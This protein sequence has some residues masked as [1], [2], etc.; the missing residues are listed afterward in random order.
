LVHVPFI[1]AIGCV[2][3][4]GNGLGWPFFSRLHDDAGKEDIFSS[5][6]LCIREKT[7]MDVMS[8]GERKDH[9]HSSHHKS[10]P[11]HNTNFPSKYLSLSLSAFYSILFAGRY[12]S[13]PTFMCGML[14]NVAII[15]VLFP[16]LFILTLTLLGSDGEWGVSIRLHRLRLNRLRLNWLGLHRLYGSRLELW[17]RLN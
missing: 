17:G 13:L 3:V 16:N 2:I 5:Q 9:L 14:L 10:L 4:G 8:Y 7:M 11:D 15:I 6:T 12:S 1:D